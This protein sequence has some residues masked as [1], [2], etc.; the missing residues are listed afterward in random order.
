MTRLSRLIDQEKI[1]A[2]C[3]YWCIYSCDKLGAPVEESVWDTKATWIN[4][5][6]KMCAFRCWLPVDQYHQESDPSWN[7]IEALHGST[8][9]LYIPNTGNK[10]INFACSKSLE[11]IVN[12]ISEGIKFQSDFFKLIHW[13]ECNRIRCTQQTG[14]GFR[15]VI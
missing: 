6:F 1:K 9:S 10:M 15:S 12:K 14:H 11:K 3:I 4:N 5:W 2:I 8:S 13:T 7:S